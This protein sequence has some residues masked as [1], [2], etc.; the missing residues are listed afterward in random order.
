MNFTFWLPMLA[1]T[2]NKLHGCILHTYNAN[3][4]QDSFM[5][6]VHQSYCWDSTKSF[7]C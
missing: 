3:I 6:T 4:T 1:D 2:N 5:V 7:G